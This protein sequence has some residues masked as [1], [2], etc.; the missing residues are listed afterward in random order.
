MH[1]YG[2]TGQGLNFVSKEK[3]KLS[4]YSKFNE[5]YDICDRSPSI[6]HIIVLCLFGI[7]EDQTVGEAI[8]LKG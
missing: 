1:C 4:Y 6:H 3:V 5:S 2:D 8:F 7:R